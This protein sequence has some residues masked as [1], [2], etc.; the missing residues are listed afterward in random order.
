MVAICSQQVFKFFIWPVKYSYLC[1]WLLSILFQHAKSI[2]LF[3]R[4]I[5][6]FQY[7]LQTVTS[8]L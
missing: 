8:L 7:S 1:T 3:Y 2:F 6:W 4:I 5:W